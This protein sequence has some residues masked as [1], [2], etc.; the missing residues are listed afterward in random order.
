M[1]VVDVSLTLAGSSPAPNTTEKEAP[2][3]APPATNRT[4]TAAAAAAAAAATA[5][6]DSNSSVVAERA[7]LSAESAALRES[8]RV[9]LE[10]YSS[11]NEID[12][13]PCYDALEAVLKN[14][15]ITEAEQ[16]ERD[17]LLEK[18]LNCIEGERLP[19]CLP[20]FS[21]LS[22]C[23]G[24]ST[25]FRPFHPG[26][27]RFLLPLS[28]YHREN[29]RRSFAF[30]SFSEQQDSGSSNRRHQARTPRRSGG[31]LWGKPARA[32]VRPLSRSTPRAL[33][34]QTVSGGPACTSASPALTRRSGPSAARPC[35]ATGEEHEQAVVPRN[36]Q[37]VVFARVGMIMTPFRRDARWCVE[38]AGCFVLFC[39]VTRLIL[40]SPPHPSKAEAPNETLHH[41]AVS[42]LPRVGVHIVPRDDRVEAAHMF[43]AGVV[44]LERSYALPRYGHRSESS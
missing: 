23:L 40:P 43:D 11:G 15:K 8:F 17:A 29:L 20:P 34:E 39:G 2:S 4:D 19:L 9:E 16:V 38:A 12:V 1:S 37:T 24:V 28:S 30:S 5:A 27:H 41:S 31:C 18:L 6:G 21:S 36:R 33:G 10:L 42:P 14:P 44:E 25:G 7:V 3:D 22:R 32:Y 35:T 26:T 13:S